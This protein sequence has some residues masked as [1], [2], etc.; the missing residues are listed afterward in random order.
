M[1]EDID[2][3]SNIPGISVPERIGANNK[4]IDFGYT[5]N[6]SISNRNVFIKNNID[7]DLRI[8][9]IETP[10]HFS[11]DNKNDVIDKI[12]PSFDSLELNISFKP[13]S[14]NN[15]EV[16][17]SIIIM[18][19]YKIPIKIIVLGETVESI[20]FGFVQFPSQITKK[21]T[22]KNSL[23]E[24]VKITDF[25]TS[26]EYLIN[27]NVKGT[28][29][30]AKDSTEIDI[31]YKPEK[32]N[33]ESK[34]TKI[35]ILKDKGNPDT[36][37]VKGSSKYNSQIESHNR[38]SIEDSLIFSK[39]AVGNTSTK[40]IKITNDFDFDITISTIEIDDP[41]FKPSEKNNINI[42]KKSSK[43]IPI[44]FSPTEDKGYTG[45]IT[46]IT[47]YGA[48][49]KVGIRVSEQNLGIFKYVNKTSNP[50]SPGFYTDIS[51]VK[52]KLNE[53]IK[54]AVN[55]NIG[56][57]LAPNDSIIILD[58]ARITRITKL[59]FDSSTD[60]ETDM[61]KH[62]INVTNF[63]NVFHSNKFDSIPKGI[64]KYCTKVTSFYGAFA[65]CDNLKYIPDSLFAHCPLNTTFE[66]TFTGC[67]SL[68]SLPGDLFAYTPL[69]ITF[70]YTFN[71][72]G[73]LK[74]LPA[75]VFSNCANVQNFEN[76][77]MKTSLDSIPP[78]LL[79]N[80]L[81][82]EKFYG[83]FKNTK[84]RSIPKGLFKY[85][86]KAKDFTTVFDYCLELTSIPDSLFAYCTD[87]EVLYGAF[88]WC[89]KLFS[90]P[91]TIMTPNTNS[92]CKLMFEGAGSPFKLIHDGPWSTI[93]GNVLY[94]NLFAKLFSSSENRTIIVENNDEYIYLGSM[95]W[96]KTP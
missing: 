93:S 40:N 55:D 49:L 50:V 76:T 67:D 17:D 51:G 68:E 23:N 87:A 31:T 94:N 43:S 24:E 47:S 58:A 91:S 80:C 96:A 6:A 21:V 34:K 33:K 8:K 65:Y 13:K 48:S 38:V 73:K 64:F 16:R 45:T 35:I 2:K 52:Y 39:T 53:T 57:T 32:E 11:I 9:E 74:N 61:F 12:I 71:E 59:S 14:L 78:G 42:P 36:L 44:N 28:V 15:A 95:N 60:M 18:T 75:T 5:P 69:N 37:S 56:E 54:T 77:F 85:T 92:N 84:I 10:T 82:A 26:S 86:T 72:C 81:S 7:F 27:E 88:Q 20:E 46:V 1:D 19:N 25:K 63:G 30:Q 79:D 89:S 83:T 4:I 62:C 90:A 70:R 29:I 41:S 3:K 66:Y 22:I